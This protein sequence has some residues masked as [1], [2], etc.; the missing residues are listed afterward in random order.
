[1]YPLSCSFSLLHSKH[2]F[3]VGFTLPSGQIG[4]DIVQV[5]GARVQFA[6]ASALAMLVEGHGEVCPLVLRHGGVASLA[7]MLHTAGAQGKKAAAEAIQACPAL[8]C[9]CLLCKQMLNEC[10]KHIHDGNTATI[11]TN[12]LHLAPPQYWLL[13]FS[14]LH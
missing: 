9:G 4:L 8:F 13:S 10:M 12:L 1:M 11:S 5:G 3:G 14:K 2:W 6:C 7:T